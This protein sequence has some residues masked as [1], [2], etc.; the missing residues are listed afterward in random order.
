MAAAVLQPGAEPFAL[1]PSAFRRVVPALAEELAGRGLTTARDLLL[2]RPSRY[3]DRRELA[4]AGRCAIGERASILAEVRRPHEGRLRRGG[5]TLTCQLADATGQ[6]TA[7]W[8]HA[9]PWQLRELTAGR[10]CFFTG[11]VKLSKQG[12]RVLFN[13]EYEAVDQDEDALH[14]GRLVPLYQGG[15][16]PRAYRTL[17]AAVLDGVLPALEDPL[18]E[19][20]R[21]AEGLWPLGRALRELHFPD[22]PGAEAEAGRRLAFDE[23]LW[24]SLGLAQRRRGARARAGFT[25]KAGAAEVERAVAGLPFV[26][27]SA[28][29]RAL[30][31]IAADL[32][33]G[34]PMQ[35]LLEGDVGS[36]KTAVAAVALRL[37]V[38]SG[39]QGALMAPTE[40]LAEQHFRSLRALLEPAGVRVL[41][42]TAGSGGARKAGDDVRAGRPLV[43][44]GTQALIQSEISFGALALAVVDEQHRFGVQDRLRLAAKGP[45]PHVLLMSATPIPRTLA[46]AVHGDLDLS[47]LDELPPGRLPVKTQLLAGKSRARAMD[48]LRAELGAGHQAYAVYPLVE[49]SEKIDLQN[50]TDAAGKLRTALPEARIGLVHGRLGAEEREA[51]MAAFRD[52]RLDVLVATTVVEVGVDVPN[53]TLM[54]ISQAERFGLSQ[55]HQLRGRVGRGTAPSRC[56]LVAHGPLPQ[57]ARRRLRALVD[58][59]DGFRLA[60]VDLELRGP[61]EVLG[62]RQS[63]LPE[64]HFADPWRERELLARARALAFELVERDPELRTPEAARL[65]RGLSRLFGGRRSL[66]D[67]G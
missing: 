13:P 29:R 44:V 40:L 41:L 3:E 18:P 63:G 51:V 9:R 67:V 43:A 25:V 49:E 50:A 61:G 11:V 31:E 15:A 4:G 30:S 64:L 66:A 52:G 60:E 7:V 36:G 17:V 33:S 6:L 54:I 65:T 23:L 26:P 27:T 28:Q 57:A 8:F 14:F 55:L 42:V 53:A 10:R 22:G 34:S 47:V 45:A 16:H 20:W 32:A 5:A 37:A 24:L 38:E 12:G 1:P 46:L 21:E 48:V 56:L 58:C 19:A 59:Q 62:T 35:R 39:W 2:R